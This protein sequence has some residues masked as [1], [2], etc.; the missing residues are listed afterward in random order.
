MQLRILFIGMLPPRPGG[1][2]VSLGQIITG[3]A[4]EGHEVCAVAPI[5]AGALV[6]EGD[7]FASARP[8]LRVYRYLL[9]AY[10]VEAY[11]PLPADVA[12]IQSK[13]VKRLAADL[14]ASFRPNV[15]IAGHEIFGSLTRDVAREAGLPWVQW[16]RGS[17]TAQIV[18]GLFGPERYTPFLDLIRSADRVV[19][20]AR[21]FAVGL[22]ERFGIRGI[23]TVPNAVDLQAFDARPASRSLRQQL[24]VPQGNQ[25]VLLPGAL[26]AR[27]RPKDFLGAATEVLKRRRDVT[28]LLA[29]TGVLHD[30]LEDFARQV[31]IRDHVRLLGWIPHRQMPEVFN[32]ADIVV[33]TTDAEGM[34]RACVEA[35]ASGCLLLASDIPAAREL[36]E[37]GKNGVLFPVGNYHVLADRIVRLLDDTLLRTDIRSRARA[38]VAGRDLESSVRLHIEQIQNALLPK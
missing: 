23:Q 28:F 34:S 37:D 27:K 8:E 15:L 22:E 33:M 19:S 20:V 14:C 6:A 31:D 36:I 16:L 29:G 1:A 24:D 21:Y 7:W 4:R 11:K 3:I 9:P 35:L 25:V 18:S 2:A 32:L 17:P 5:T 13:Q 30:E 12:E 38:S 10:Y 26:I